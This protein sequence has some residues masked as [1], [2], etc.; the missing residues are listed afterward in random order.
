[1]ELR[2]E[3]VWRQPL[4]ADDSVAA[5]VGPD[6]VANA[7]LDVEEGE[8][9]AAV[10]RLKLGLLD[11]RAVLFAFALVPEL[12]PVAADPA[13]GVVVADVAIS[14]PRVVASIRL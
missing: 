13:L 5:M 11:A 4:D 2:L 1:M 7:T 10:Q 9:V 12:V 8:G 3:P 14:L 6:I